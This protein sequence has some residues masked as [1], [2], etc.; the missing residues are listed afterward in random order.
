MNGMLGRTRPNIISAMLL[1][2]LASLGSGCASTQPSRGQSGFIEWEVLNLTIVGNGSY[3]FT[4]VLRDTA[5][6]GVSFHGVKIAFP[7]ASPPVQD[8]LFVHRL[9]PHSTITENLSLQVVNLFGRG[10]FPPYVELQF[11]G[12][13]DASKAIDVTIRVYR[14]AGRQV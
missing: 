7:D 8:R 12:V 3:H 13:D 4:V 2:A 5:G 10:T 1:V 6:V 9:E 14:S 11:R